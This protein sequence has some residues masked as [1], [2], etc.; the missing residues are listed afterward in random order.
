MLAITRLSARPLAR[1][2]A[3]RPFP[4][5]FSARHH[6]GVGRVSVGPRS[7]MVLGGTAAAA[8][9]RV[10]SAS[11]FLSRASAGAGVTALSRSTSS[12]ASSTASESGS[13]SGSE[14]PPPPST[15]LLPEFSLHTKTILITG[16]G[17]GL[18]LVQAEA[19]LEAGATVYALD[20]LSSPSPEFAR[21]QEKARRLGTRLEYAR[22]DVRD[23]QALRGVV[24]GIAEREGGIE[25]LIAAAGIQQETSAI[26]YTAEDA[27]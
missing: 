14:T 2:P 26:E 23:V 15:P 19:L 16:G 27:K 13:G 4:R 3:V 9:S 18:G 21:I 17:R 1:A 8:T 22:V 7:R 11:P 5:A 10:T 24:D 12:R 20:R 25:G 6:G